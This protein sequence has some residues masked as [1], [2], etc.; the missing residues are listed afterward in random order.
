MGQTGEIS[1]SIYDA[2]IRDIAAQHAQGGMTLEQAQAQTAKATDAYFL[3][4][5]GLVSNPLSF[6]QATMMPQAQPEE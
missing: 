2:Q 1:K 3:R 5:T 6:A 4:N